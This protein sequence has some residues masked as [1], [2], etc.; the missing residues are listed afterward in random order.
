MT[1][2]AIDRIKTPTVPTWCAVDALHLGRDGESDTRR[3]NVA[4]EVPVAFRYNGFSHAVMMATPDD[5]NDFAAGFSLTEG[6]I[7][8]ANDI[9]DSRN[10]WISAGPRN[11]P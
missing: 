8:G 6:I 11:V 2:F 5:L 7:Q 3:P 4:E 9:V 1:D 10:F